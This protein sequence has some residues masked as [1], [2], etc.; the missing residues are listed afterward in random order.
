MIDP[1]HQRR[2]IGSKLVK[3]V[4]A[5]ADE[6]GI[7][8]H[9]VSS[10]ES[11]SMYAK[12]GGFESLKSWTVDNGYWAREVARLERELGIFN[13]GNEG[14]EGELERA[15]EGVTEVED[16]MVR[17]PRGGCVAGTWKSLDGTSDI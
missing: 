7:A 6:A 12:V 4:L 1:A 13:V 17:Q 11:R 10:A 9:L 2:G 14:E 5:V 8:T 16:C 3:T 15:F